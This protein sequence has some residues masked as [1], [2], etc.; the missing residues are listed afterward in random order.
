M[1]SEPV[2]PSHQLPQLDGL[3]GLAIASILV[4]HFSQIAFGGALGFLN[5]LGTELFFCLS[6]F[7]VTRTLLLTRVGERMTG[8][9]KRR[10]LRRFY[11]RRG[12]RI[13]PLYFSIVA[14][15][16][17]VALPGVPP[18]REVIGW[19][20][21]YTVNI[22]LCLNG[23]GALGALSHF[24]SL[25]VIEQFYLAW[26]W[27]VL[28]AK[29]KWLVPGA[30]AMLAMAPLY[31][32]YGSTHG[33]G[34]NEIYYFT[35]SCADSIGA[36]ALLAILRVN[37][38][39]EGELE[40][41]L[42]KVALPTGLVVS[43]AIFFGPTLR[44]PDTFEAGWFGLA[45]ALVF[46]WLIHFASKGFGGKAGALLGWKPV[47]FLGRISYATYLFHGLVAFAVNTFLFGFPGLSNGAIALA[48]PLLGIPL[49][50]VLASVSWLLL[51]KP[52]NQLRARY[53]DDAID[54]R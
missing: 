25:S 18:A 8:Y 2:E 29:R 38:S 32:W 37:S 33:F 31:R 30:A 50:L 49:T 47:E 12:L 40:W 7:L 3:R 17:T 9:E 26:P 11:L 45:H 23:P 6:G 28:F 1:S 52:I 27:F 14:V 42:R 41:T 4:Y 54:S 35:L 16:C 24:W 5:A 19:L 34:P 51:E 13:L 39:S 20:L 48:S 21:T 10:V 43:L 15:A 53:R 44:L 36:G 46:V 22:D